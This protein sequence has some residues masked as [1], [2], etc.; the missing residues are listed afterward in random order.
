MVFSPRDS[1][2]YSLS[3]LRVECPG[4]TLDWLALHATHVPYS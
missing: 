2:E 1:R 3:D 4:E